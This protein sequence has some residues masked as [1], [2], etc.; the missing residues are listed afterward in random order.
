MLSHRPIIVYGHPDTGVVK[1]ARSEGWASVVSKQD[2]S[3]LMNEIELLITNKDKAKQLT[4]CSKTT[5]EKY[6]SLSKNQKT[7]LDALQ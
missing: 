4:D 1:Y 3:L 6:H 7:L 2:L 5:F